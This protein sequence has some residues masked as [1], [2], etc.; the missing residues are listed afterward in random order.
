VRTHHERFDG[1]GYPD[2][3]AGE[4]IPLAARIFAL[5]DT[6]DAITTDR[7]YRPAAS[8]AEARTTIAAGAGTQF[9]PAVVAAFEELPDEQLDRI[10]AEI[11]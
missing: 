5:A 9:D 8:M 10:R 1:S 2:G 3:L 11:R 6:L 7:P 4:E